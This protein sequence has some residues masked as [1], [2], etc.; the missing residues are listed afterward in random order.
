MNMNKK[1]IALSV[2]LLVVGLFYFSRPTPTTNGLSNITITREFPKTTIMGN[3]FTV[4]LKL[5]SVG[6][7]HNLIVTEKIP[8]GFIIPQTNLT[9]ITFNLAYKFDPETGFFAGNWTEFNDSITYLVEISENAKGEYL[10][11]GEYTSDEM[12]GNVIGDEI[13]MR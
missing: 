5:N 10:F 2:I 11:Q 13:L 8:E 12:D 7:I 4:T 3:I 6:E 9:E 1:V